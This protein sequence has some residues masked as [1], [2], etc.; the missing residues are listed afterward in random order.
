MKVTIIGALGRMGRKVTELCL[1]DK[2]IEIVGLVDH[3]QHKDIN[4]KLYPSLPE[5]S[6]DIDKCINICDVVIDFSSP[7]TL[8][9]ILNSC[10]KYTKPAVIGT[11]G[12]S[13][14]QLNF[15]KSVSKNIPIVYSSNMSIGVNIMFKLVEYIMKILKDKDYDIEIIEAH[16]NKKKDSPSGTAKKIVEI[17]KQFRPEINLIFGR[18]GMVGERKKNEVGVFAVRAGD[19]VG[20]HKVLFASTGER[21]EINHIATSRDVF[22]KGA[23]FAA[24]WVIGKPAGLY[25]MFDVLGL[26]DF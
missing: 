25:G 20:E 5:T 7:E 3:P 2:D 1:E 26:Q 8:D 4:K 18:E 10:L 13:N 19:I 12:H 24:R 21:L 9:K 17:I 15:I 22:A 6:S 16:H 23:I 11:T 14:E